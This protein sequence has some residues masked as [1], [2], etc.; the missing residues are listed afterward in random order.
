MSSIFQPTNELFIV[1]RVELLS[2]CL[3]GCDV[4]VLVPTSHGVMNKHVD[5][6]GGGRQGDREWLEDEDERRRSMG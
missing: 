3:Y 5:A 4:G 6:A 2:C 1:S